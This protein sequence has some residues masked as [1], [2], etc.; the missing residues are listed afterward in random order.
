MRRTRMG[1]LVL[2]G[3]LVAMNPARGGAEVVPLVGDSTADPAATR[4]LGSDP[5]LGVSATRTAFIRFDLSALPA[6]TTVHRA[7]L[8]I[9]VG[10][11]LAAGSLAV[12]RVTGPWDEDTLTAA[13]QPTVETQLP[14]GLTLAADTPFLEYLSIDVTAAVQAWLAGQPNHGLAL[15]GDTTVDVELVSKENPAVPQPARLEIVPGNPP[16]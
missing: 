16:D 11:L 5:A 2:S 15:R 4:P 1:L 6:G 13:R 10:R 7:T 9:Y 3:L 14:E 12:H 8:S